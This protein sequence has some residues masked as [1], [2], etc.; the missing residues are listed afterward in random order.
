MSLNFTLN[1][2]FTVLG[3]LLLDPNLSNGD[4]R[5]RPTACLLVAGSATRPAVPLPPL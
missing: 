1:Q 2:V 5:V 4:L 3:F